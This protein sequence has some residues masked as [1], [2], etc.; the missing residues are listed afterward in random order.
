MGAKGST[1]KGEW[2]P[3]VVFLDEP[4]EFKTAEEAIAKTRELR[5]RE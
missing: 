4:R 3:Y 1:S 2:R 5:G